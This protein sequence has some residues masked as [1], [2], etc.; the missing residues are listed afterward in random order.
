MYPTLSNVFLPSVEAINHVPYASFSKNS[1]MDFSWKISRC[2]INHVGGRNEKSNGKYASMPGKF[3]ISSRSLG[4]SSYSF[5]SGG[6]RNLERWNVE[7]YLIQNQKIANIKIT[8]DDLFDS[9][10]IEFNF[11]SFFI[12]YLN[13][14]I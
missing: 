10:N 13:Q 5:S 9:F 12:N 6:S 2:A 3:H 14:N 1:P 7:L 11:F 4:K 8:K